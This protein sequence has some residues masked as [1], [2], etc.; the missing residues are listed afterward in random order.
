MTHDELRSIVFE[1][2]RERRRV[3]ASPQI[4]DD[5]P[6]VSA[7]AV[8]SLGFLDL[9]AHLEQQSGQEV[10]LLEVDPDELLTIGG[11]ARYFQV[12]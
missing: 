9:I 10:D 11:L 6:L 4:D 1:F 12:S 3:D 5:T 8:D 7:E 2:V